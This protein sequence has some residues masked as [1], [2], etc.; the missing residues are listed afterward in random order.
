MRLS[1]SLPPAGFTR[2]EPRPPGPRLRRPALIATTIV[3][4]TGL[5]LAAG[6]TTTRTAPP[7]TVTPD[8]ATPVPSAERSSPSPTPASGRKAAESRRTPSAR[9]SSPP[10][11]PP[12]RERAVPQRTRHRPVRHPRPPATH[13][14]R[15][16]RPK[17]P[18]W[19]GPECR[20]RFPDDPRRR[21]ACVA[22]LTQAFGG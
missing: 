22:A 10:R 6:F 13:K 14:A 18:S 12:R 11:R 3:L 5:L 19:I 17:A 8:A 20:R 15:P 2:A 9:R 16:S 21:A 1:S 7:R 4:G